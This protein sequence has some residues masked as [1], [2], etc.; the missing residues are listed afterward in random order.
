MFMEFPAELTLHIA[1]YLDTDRD[2]SALTRT[3]RLLYQR[4]H[5]HLYTHN[6]QCS[7][8]TALLWAAEHGVEATARAAIDAGADVN[9]GADKWGRTSG[10]PLSRA[11]FHGHE[12]IVALLLAARGIAPEEE[13]ETETTF[14]HVAAMRGHVAIVKQLLDAGQVDINHGAGYG[15]TPLLFASEEGHVDV[16]KFLLA[17]PDVDARFESEF[18][19]RPYGCAVQHDHI[20]VIK[21]FFESGKVD[22]GEK[23]TRSGETA[24]FAAAR[25]GDLD[26]FKWLLASGRLDVHDEGYR[27]ETLLMAAAGKDQLGIIHYLLES[28]LGDPKSRNWKGQTMLSLAAENGSL[29]TVRY[30]LRSGLVDID[31]KHDDGYTPLS[32]AA[33]KGHA[34]VVRELITSGK[35][36]ANVEN[37]K[38]ISVLSLAAAGD[39]C[40][41]VRE[42]LDSGKVDVNAT[43]HRGWTAL[44]WA[45]YLGQ[46]SV[47]RLL[48]GTYGVDVN[49]RDVGG[50]TAYHYACSHKF[51][52]RRHL[53]LDCSDYCQ[54]VKLFVDHGADLLAVSQAGHTALHLAAY[55]GC[56]ELVEYLVGKT[57]TVDARDNKGRTPYLLATMQGRNQIQGMLAHHSSID[58]AVDDLGNTPIFL[59]TRN[60]HYEIVRAML[61]DR[62]ALVLEKDK[63]GRTLLYAAA[64]SHTPG[65]LEDTEKLI[66]LLRKHARDLR[67]E[68]EL[69]DWDNWG[70]LSSGSRT[71]GPTHVSIG[72]RSPLPE[73]KRNWRGSEAKGKR[74]PQFP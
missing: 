20:A 28:G 69:G 9:I 22:I 29:E 18:H 74:Y 38:G 66:A 62:P 10:C 40:N 11:A 43:D 7:G 25:T 36:D 48:L 51:H 14:L 49:T 57:G 6:A 13:Y 46:A 44:F 33:E 54:V 32:K 2:I 3:C 73:E 1:E 30:L 23:H 27:G 64:M 65:K 15:R 67:V 35:V 68:S 72:G 45:A 24:L 31:T 55:N 5:E 61:D 60:Q 21:A 50:H 8:S 63:M 71:G 58:T 37:E 70:A 47:V 42:L 4:L 17:S 34:Q 39:H 41:V 59:A 56:S 26:F 19:G 52:A 12:D 16:V 53:R